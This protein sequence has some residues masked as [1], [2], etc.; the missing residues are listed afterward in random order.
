MHTHSIQRWEHEHAFLGGSHRR[1]EAR[2]RLVVSLTVIMA[3]VEI[4][5]GVW[6]GSM[7]LLAD[8]W[9][10]ATHA[11]ALGLA[12][13]AYIYARRHVGAAHFAFGTGKL[14]DLAGFAGAVGLGLIALLI[15]WESLVR[16]AS[17]V[18]IHFEEA[19][20]IAVL[21]LLVNLASAALL[22][23]TQDD[24]HDHNLRAAYLHVL[25]DA[26]TS[27]LAIAGL[28]AGRQ[29]GWVWLDPVIGMI[30]AVVIARWSLGLL[31]DAGAVLLD[32]VPHCD[33]ASSV[34]GV[35]EQGGDR[36]T[37]LHLWRVGPGHTAAIIALVSDRP[38][39]PAHYKGQL[40]GVVRL[41]HV[42]IEVNACMPGPG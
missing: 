7:A 35:L 37:D 40:A 19:I 36:V 32:A 2:T 21:G 4:A 42:T 16:L 38:Q 28:L 18:S 29:L 41:S 3:V 6:S 10:M 17:P 31:R 30:G 26:L 12:A 22:R 8:G 34:R 33:V 11:G 24:A 13:A 5:A 25:A 23:E 39:P 27:I 9:H 15:G 14:G 1:N 20:A